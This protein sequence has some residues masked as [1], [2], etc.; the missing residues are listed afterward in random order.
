MIID[1]R[2]AAVESVINAGV[3]Y[4]RGD[5]QRALGY[6]PSLR[7]RRL[8]HS[9]IHPPMHSRSCSLPLL[10]PTHPPISPIKNRHGVEA[11][12]HMLSG[13]GNEEAR[14]KAEKEKTNTAADVI[15]FSGCRD[16]Q[17]SA[18]VNKDGKATGAASFALLSCLRAKPNQNYTELLQNMRKALIE[19]PSHPP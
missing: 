1:N 12:K 11:I 17:T 15:Q 2:R 6:V 14:K 8:S 10:Q 7:E 18:D 13:G 4:A 3:A 16:N 9:F 19:G 5:K